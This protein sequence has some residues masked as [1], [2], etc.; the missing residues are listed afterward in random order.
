MGGLL[1]SANDGELLFI[2]CQLISLVCWKL[3]VHFFS[4]PVMCDFSS[5]PRPVMWAFLLTGMW[6]WGPSMSGIGR[7]LGS[8]ERGKANGVWIERVSIEG[9]IYSGPVMC[10]FSRLGVSP[11]LF[12][13]CRL[14]IIHPYLGYGC[15]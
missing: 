15:D 4:W 12:V 2:W 10:S 5:R 9:D 1:L 3:R 13:W 14:G 6:L 8:V 11:S 7:L